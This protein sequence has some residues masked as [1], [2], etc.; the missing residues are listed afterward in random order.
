[1]GD[2][3]ASGQILPNTA[4]PN[5][6]R[7]ARERTRER[8]L[9]LLNAE[10]RLFQ[11]VERREKGQFSKIVEI[12]HVH[13]YMWEETMRYQVSPSAARASVVTLLGLDAMRM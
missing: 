4:S 10:D 7:S 1:M 9:C 5:P 12:V 11:N 6:R 2:E 3:L 13:T 8:C